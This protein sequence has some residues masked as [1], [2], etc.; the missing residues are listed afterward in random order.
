MM[1][2]YMKFNHNR[3]FHLGETE[4]NA[5]SKHIVDNDADKDIRT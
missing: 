4:L 2:A 1:Y 3:S 5:V